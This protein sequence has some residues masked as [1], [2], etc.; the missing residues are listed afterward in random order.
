MKAYFHY[1]TGCFLRRRQV[2]EEPGARSCIQ[3]AFSMRCSHTFL[4]CRRCSQTLRCRMYLPAD[5]ALQIVYVNGLLQTSSF[6]LILVCCGLALTR[7]LVRPSWRS[8]RP[9]YTDCYSP[10]IHRVSGFLS[11]SRMLSI[12]ADFHPPPTQ[13]VFSAREPAVKKKQKT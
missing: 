5:F 13:I 2:I 8:R 7:S 4:S 12:S 1:K 11:F 10:H 9:L 6:S 3:I